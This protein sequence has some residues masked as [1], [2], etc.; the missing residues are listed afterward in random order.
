MIFAYLR[1]K[2]AKNGKGKNKKEDTEHLQT[3]KREIINQCSICPK[4]AL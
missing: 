3:A 2:S 1:E 4:D